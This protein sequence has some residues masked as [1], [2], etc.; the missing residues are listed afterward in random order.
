M[1]TKIKSFTDLKVWQ[2]AHILVIEVYKT[3][4]GF[5]R[6]EIFGLTSQMKRASVSIT[7]NIAEGFSRRSAKEKIQ[8][9]SIAHGS[10]TE[11]QNQLLIA[12]DVGYINEDR[13]KKFSQQTII[14]HKLLNA[15]IRTTR[16][17]DS[18]FKTLNYKNHS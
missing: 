2:E 11:L 8:F 3:V 13:F 15:F 18:K 14:A 12:R 1:E 6:E 9:Y 10:L 5:P 4:K 17:L 7:S 16:D